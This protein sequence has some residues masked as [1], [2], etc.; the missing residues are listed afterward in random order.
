MKLRRS[1]PI[2]ILSE[3]NIKTLREAHGRTFFG[4]RFRA[5]CRI[6]NDCNEDPGPALLYQEGSGPSLFHH[7]LSYLSQFCSL[8]HFQRL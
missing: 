1:I 6:R 3:Q 7:T 5:L 4:S 2:V 8:H